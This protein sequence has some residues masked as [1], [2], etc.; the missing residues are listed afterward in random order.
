MTFEQYLAKVEVCKIYSS[1]KHFSIIKSSNSSSDLAGPDFSLFHINKH[2]RSGAFH[3][4]PPH[5]TIMPRTW[6][7]HFSCSRLSARGSRGSRAPFLLEKRGVLPVLTTCGL[8][9]ANT[10]TPRHAMA[11]QPPH[12]VRRT[13]TRTHI[14]RRDGSRLDVLKRRPL[15]GCLLVSTGALSS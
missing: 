10:V 9:L 4:R 5:I 7:R 12:R 14:G 8:L 3:H 13:S 15:A 6:P 1:R 11:S 2:Q